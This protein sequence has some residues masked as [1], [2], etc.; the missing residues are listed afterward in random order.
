MPLP[1]TIPN[2]FANATA[3]IPLSQLDNNFSTV[4]VAVNSIGN[5]AFSLAN[6]QVTGGKIANVVLDN[7]SVDVETLSNVTITNLTV[8]GNATF[9]NAAVTANTAT[10]TTATF[11]AGSNTAPSI[12]TSGDTNTGIYFPAADTIAFTEGGVESMRI[13]SSGRL[14]VGTTSGSLS[15]I[16]AVTADGAAPANTSGNNALRLRS[17]AT[18]AVGAG[19]SIL[20]EGQT[21]NTTAQYGFAAIQGFKDSAGVNDY[22]GAMAFYTQNSGGS[23]SLTERMRL[24]SGGRLLIGATSVRSGFAY[25]IFSEGTPSNFTGGAGFVHNANSTAGPAIGFGKSRGTTAGS[26]TAVASGDVLGQLI[27]YGADGTGLIEAA[28]IRV[29]VDGTPGT[30]DMPGRLIFSTTA[31]G[32]STSTERMRIDSSGNVGIGTSSPSGPLNVVSAS[33]SLAIAINGRSSDSLGAM[34][35]YANNGTTQHATITASATEFRLSSVPAAAV[36]T[37]YTNGS[38]RARITSGGAL[39]VGTTSALG[40]VKFIVESDTTT[41]N[42]MTVSNTRATAATDYAI[43]FYRAGNIVGSVQTSLSATTFATSSDYRLK[44]NIA[45]MTDALAKVAQLNPVTYTWK[46]DGSAG[47]GFI[48][49]EL[50]EVVPDAVTGEKD[51][52]NEDGSIK[53]QGIDT[54]FLVATL[55]AALQELNAKVETLQAEVAALKGA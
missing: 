30:N 32:A 5:G 47:E 39:C 20:F 12:T 4:A 42:P 41:L 36:Q 28:T 3:T 10:I 2:T 15:T 35:F 40:S 22:S 21:G 46:S 55:T 29:N 19:P 25:S 14:L 44:E 17:T 43:I 38:V 51:A 37:F 52:V 16:V 45:P 18:A 1:I 34:Y 7:V 13:D 26:V 54:S 11:G 9:T 48:A 33:S 24:D 53:P 8:N 31:D 49:H 6:V 50:A 27:F 23:T